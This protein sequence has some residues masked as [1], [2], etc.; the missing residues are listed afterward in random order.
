MRKTTLYTCLALASSVLVSGTT[1][2][3]TPSSTTPANA[4]RPTLLDLLRHGTD[5]NLAN[6][7]HGRG[8]DHS[9]NH[10]SNDDRGSASSRGHGADDGAGHEHHG[11]GH[12]GGN[13]D[14]P[15]D[16]HGGRR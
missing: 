5:D 15:G 3:A 10:A 12:G 6:G 4:A 14:G 7:H 16:D 2:N 9:P 13:D 8:R 1:V 11:G